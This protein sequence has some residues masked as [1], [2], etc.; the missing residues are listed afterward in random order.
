MNNEWLST[1]GVTNGT[2]AKDWIGLDLSEE[3]MALISGF[4]I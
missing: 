1:H 2:T 3:D 4:L